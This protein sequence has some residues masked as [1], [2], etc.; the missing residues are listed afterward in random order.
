MFKKTIAAVLCSAFVTG[1]VSS[2]CFCA[3]DYTVLAN[4]YAG[5]EKAQ[6]NEYSYGWIEIFKAERISLSEG[7]FG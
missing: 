3:D 4:Y 2:V 5:M 6:F 7:V 1:G